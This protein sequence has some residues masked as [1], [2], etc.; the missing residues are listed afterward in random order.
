MMCTPVN[1]HKP[2]Y[3][4]CYMKTFTEEWEQ[5]C[6]EGNDFD[7][8]VSVIMDLRDRT[9]ACFPPTQAPTAYPTSAPSS[10]TAVPT[11]SPTGKSPPSSRKRL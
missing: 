8:E 6:T 7:Y 11:S 5:E 3:P 9:T 1:N 2:P 4:N 10:L